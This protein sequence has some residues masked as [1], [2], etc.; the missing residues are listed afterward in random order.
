MSHLR[1]Q[2][3]LLSTQ[4]VNE[5]FSVIFKPEFR[6]VTVKLKMSI[7]WHCVDHVLF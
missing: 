5:T 2:F 1:F 4:N 6:V 3:E 7:P